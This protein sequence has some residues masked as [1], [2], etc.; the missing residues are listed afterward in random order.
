MPVLKTFGEFV[1]SGNILVGMVIFL[2]ITVVQ[3]VVITKGGERIA[4]V[5][6]RFLSIRCPASR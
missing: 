4:E 1:I 2:I 3:F 5:S 6:A